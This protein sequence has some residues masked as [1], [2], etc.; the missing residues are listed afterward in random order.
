MRESP[1]Y[2]RDYL[3]HY[4]EIDRERRLTLPALMHYF[5][6]IATLDSE[7]RGF[8]LDRYWSAGRLFLLLKWDIAVRSWPRF[9]ETLRIETRP[10][11]F[12]R[13][14]ANREY[15]VFGSG[16]EPVAEARTV[17][18]FT[19][20]KQKK[21]VRVPGE[22]YEAFG[23]SPQSEASFDMQEEL[24]EI[25]AA[26]L[27]PAS[28]SGSAISTTTITSTTSG[29]SNGRWNRFRRISSAAASSAG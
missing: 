21:P 2:S 14:L 10:T 13:F 1:P 28:G 9:N 3:V 22:I 6:D 26:S 11:T 24:P 25:A 4:Y 8:T 23:V 17:W 27:P 12:K 7:A 5:E 16:G 29:T 20:I 15:A 19:D 18:I